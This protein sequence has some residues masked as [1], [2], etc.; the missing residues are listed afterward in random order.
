M[1]DQESMGAGSRP[2]SAR[3]YPSSSSRPCHRSRW[4]RGTPWNCACRYLS[5]SCHIAMCMFLSGCACPAAA[6]GT[7]GPGTEQASRGVPQ[8][9]RRCYST[10]ASSADTGYQFHR[11]L[12]I[13]LRI[14][15]RRL[16][17]RVPKNGLGH[18]QSVRPQF[19]GP[20]VPQPVWA[21]C[22]HD[23]LILGD[24]SVLLVRGGIGLPASP[25]DGAPV[26]MRVV[27][28]SRRPLPLRL[29]LAALMTRP[30]GRLPLRPPPRI[31]PRLGLSGA[32][33]IGV[34]LRAQKWAQYF[35]GLRA[36]EDHAFV[37][38]VRGLVRPVRSLIAAGTVDPA[39]RV[40]H[41]DVDGADEAHLGRS[42]AGEELQTNQSAD[43][44]RSERQGGVNVFLGDGLHLL[45]F[46]GFALARP[47]TGDGLQVLVDTARQHLLFRC[48]PKRAANAV[49]LGVGVGA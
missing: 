1:M 23:Y 36:N 44:R 21:P 4:G 31:P 33:A 24:G 28:I 8:P 30:E 29:G 38:V 32:E 7:C 37:A 40:S 10:L 22:R 15:L 13:L 26:T 18:V 5:A 27:A 2:A 16:D 17:L 3:G 46:A 25:G 49:D 42:A 41:V 45:R 9:S 43:G 34:Q 39:G 11:R 35:L 12:N 6:P 20:V 14:N 48:P 19:R 47:Q